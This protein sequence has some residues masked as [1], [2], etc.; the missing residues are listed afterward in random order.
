MAHDHDSGRIQWASKVPQSIIRRLYETDA[1]G[2]ADDELIDKVGWALWER[3]DSILTVTAA[4]Y[5][6]VRCPACGT[7]IER[8]Q[9]SPAD[10]QV[11]CGA[12]GWQVAWATYHQSYRGKQLFGANAVAVFEAYHAAFPQA[13]AAKP[14]M[15]LIDQLI[16]AFHVG[17][18]DIGRPVAANLIEGKLAEVIR[19]LDALTNGDASGA[20]ASDARAAWRRTL[21]AASWSRPFIANDEH[22]EG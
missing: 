19:F 17:L 9:G 15:L 18:T 8:Q 1:R 7:L 4:H 2:I 5:G 3:C 11:I 20:G 22:S 21:E 10:E 14:K 16:H 6:R 13:Q 12:C